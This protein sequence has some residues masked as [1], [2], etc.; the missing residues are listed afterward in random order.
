MDSVYKNG[1]LFEILNND[2]PV[3]KVI[4]ENSNY[5][6]LPDYTFYSFRLTNYHVVNTD[7]HVWIE[8]T[9]VGIWR[10]YPKS[11]IVI[12]RCKTGA[13][14]VTKKPYIKEY[15]TGLIKVLFVPEMTPC[16]NCDEEYDDRMVKPD[17]TIYR[18]NCSEYTDSVTPHT[19]NNRKCSLTAQQYS[20]PSEFYKTDELDKYH[21]RNIMKRVKPLQNINRYMATEMYVRIVVDNDHSI[22]QRK[23]AIMREAQSNIP[24]PVM[25]RE[26]PQRPFSYNSDAP[27]ALS[28]VYRFSNF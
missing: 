18:W 2:E 20:E 25:I 7:V 23:Y 4:Y 3:E 10:I 16:Y 9:K 12:D 11:R 27:F 13:R 21:K 15:L 1:F 28:H 5:F 22:Y 19:N 17:P 14:F 8:G 26:H 6:S 24:P